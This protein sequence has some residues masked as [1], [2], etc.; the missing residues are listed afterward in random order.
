M[1]RIKSLAHSYF[2]W[3][4]DGLT[5]RGSF[6]VLVLNVMLLTGTH[7]KHLLIHGWS[8]N[9][10]GKECLWVMLSLVGISCWLLFM[11][12][13][14][15][16]KFTLFSST[17]TQQTIDKLLYIFACHGLPTTLVSDNGPPF[18]S[19]EFFH[20]VTT[21]GIL[22]RRV[23]PYHPSYNR[24]T[25]NVVK[26]VKHALNKAKI[27]KDVHTVYTYCLLFLPH[28]RI[29]ST[30]QHL[31]HRQSYYLTVHHKLVTP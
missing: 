31:E 2:W 11:P 17:S 3:G 28:I 30:S 13:L 4:R 20:F 7:Q 16:L 24:L 23:P 1:S 10:H 9:T 5:N 19:A 29:L 15:G 25:E 8:P 6:V 22:H 14:S 18:Q 26:T 27:T 21:N 12:S